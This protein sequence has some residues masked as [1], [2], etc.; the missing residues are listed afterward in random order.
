MPQCQ[1]KIYFKL[2][3]ISKYMT[4][5]LIDKLSC[6]NDSNIQYSHVENRVKLCRLYN[7]ALIYLTYNRARSK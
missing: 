7:A 2:I 3:M 1:E 6:E 5:C 4:K